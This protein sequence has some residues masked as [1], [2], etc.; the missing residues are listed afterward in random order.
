M[1]K[2]ELRFKGKQILSTIS[3]KE[4][5]EMEAKMHRHLFASELWKR[6][7]VVGVTLSQSHEWS[8]E[9]IIEEGWR[10]G[11]KMVVPKCS[12]KEK[13]MQFYQLDSYDQLERVYF[14]LR[15]PKPNEDS[16]IEKDDIELLL[17]PG[18]LFDIKGYRIGYGGGYYDRFIEGYRGKTMMVASTKQKI[19][20]LPMEEYD[21]RVEYILT[22]AGIQSTYQF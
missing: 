22:E 8:T 14:G 7:K 4:R 21:Q 6:A 9:P 1:D 15:E 3:V 10:A 16:K 2:T 11:K 17:V 13:E 18:L 19:D 5:Q 20:K 12:P